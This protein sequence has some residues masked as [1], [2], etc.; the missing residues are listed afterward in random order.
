MKR[1]LCVAS[2]IVA[3]AAGF[4]IILLL[5]SPQSVQ[6]ITSASPAQLVA[7]KSES[8]APLA[9]SGI[10]S[11]V[12][13]IIQQ[14]VQATV[15]FPASTFQNA[16][17]KAVR[18]VFSGQVRQIQGPFVEVLQVYAFGGMAIFGNNA[19]P[20]FMQRIGGLMSQAAV[21]LWA[22]SLALMGLAVL[23][24]N[25]AGLGYG[26]SDAAGEFA[27]WLFIAMASGN[28][29]VIVNL[30]HAG[31]GALTGA[32]I[33]LG[34]IGT[35][36]QFVT[37]FL[38]SSLLRPEMPILILVVAVILGVIT[39]VIMA[40]TY[41]ARYVLLL[42]VAGLAPLAI[43]CEGIPFT[44]ILFRDWLSLFLKLEILSV[45]NALILVLLA[46][47]GALIVSQQGVVGALMSL[48]MMVGLSSAI[49][50]VNMNAFKSVFGT[51]LQ[52]VQEARQAIGQVVSAVGVLAGAGASI[53]L[54]G[55]TL[56]SNALGGGALGAASGS[57]LTGSSGVSGAA[58]TGTAT[59]GSVAATSSTTASSN[60]G[61]ASTSPATD[62]QKAD[63]DESTS[64]SSAPDRQRPLANLLGSLVGGVGRATGSGALSGF[65]T[66]LSAGARYAS[67]TQSNSDAT[68]AEAGGRSAQYRDATE[69]RDLIRATGA[70]TP[71]EVAEV[72]TA[73]TKLEERYGKQPARQAVLAQAPLLNAATRQYRDATST[74][75]AFGYSGYGQLVG[76]FAEEHLRATA[77]PSDAPHPEP[78]FGAPPI[79]GQL[80]AGPPTEDKGITPYDFAAASAMTSRLRLRPS[81]AVGLSRMA[82]HM[83][84]SPSG[85]APDGYVASA[86]RLSREIGQSANDPDQAYAEFR[87]AVDAMD[88]AG[89]TPWR[90]ARN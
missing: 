41:I 84:T 77:P 62:S 27:R 89:Y 19:L 58:T 16:I 68:Q 9:Q 69:Q 66:G 12:Q 56:A 5:L 14:I 50:A 46:N 26:T 74:A 53:A 90:P 23:T 45:V 22:I 75:T 33:G 67:E 34:A 61:S 76:A 63:A 2:P 10:I 73:V 87:R 28:G 39:M 20:D 11:G 37:G 7:P 71:D 57:A 8:G 38:S 24:R 54:G 82:H 47:F 18:N 30:V 86:L 17:E 85:A 78:L 80:E 81:A 42:V 60:K 13:S 88:Y 21:P 6:A 1:S 83:R 51:A 64:K 31:F 25:A 32:V 15:F 43:A 4:A 44:R 72:K 59:G 55:G 29:I 40:V 3:S 48:V 65:G 70:R 36:Q 35:A 79:E 52:A 49:I